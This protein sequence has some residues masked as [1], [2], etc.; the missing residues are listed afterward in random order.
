MGWTAPPVERT[1]QLGDLGTVT[2]RQM[3][4]G[5]Y[6][7]HN[8]CADFLRARSGYE[9]VAVP[10]PSCPLPIAVLRSYGSDVRPSVGW[11]EPPP[12]N[13]GLK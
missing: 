10:Q 5:R 6:A 8:G 3:L 11:S 7:R 12:P 2:E 1:R 9:R 13:S 4:E